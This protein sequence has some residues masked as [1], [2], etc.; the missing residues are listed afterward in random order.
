MS[1]PQQGGGRA[2]RSVSRIRSDVPVS[3][4]DSKHQDKVVEMRAI[5]GCEGFIIDR[6]GQVEAED[7]RP[8]VVELLHFERHTDS[9]LV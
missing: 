3:G 6:C 8:S 2:G 7:F 5:Y 9:P 4:F 1:R